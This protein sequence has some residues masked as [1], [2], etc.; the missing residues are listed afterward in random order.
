MAER[1]GVEAGPDA[2]T[3]GHHKEQPPLRCQH[4]PDFAQHFLRGIGQLQPVHHERHVH[5]ALQQWQVA[6]IDQCRLHRAALRPAENPLPGHHESQLRLGLHDAI[7]KVGHCITE[8]HDPCP[9][10]A[11]QPRLQLAGQRTPGGQ[12]EPA[13]VKLPQIDDI[14]RNRA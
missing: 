4:P 12:A 10:H 13:A 2:A 6:F 14:H 11:G 9:S 7:G 1:R 3:V 5:H 8:P